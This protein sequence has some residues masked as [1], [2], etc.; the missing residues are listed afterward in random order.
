MSE[1]TGKLPS[2]MTGGSSRYLFR[3]SVPT[4]SQPPSTQNRLKQLEAATS[5][6]ITE[7][8]LDGVL[9]RAVQVSAQVI[10]AKYAAIGVLAPDG[11]M[12]EHFTTHG[13]DSDLAARIGTP[14]RG[15]GILGVVIREAKP[16]RLSDLTKH[17][18][19]YG[20][21]PHHPPMRSFLGV[22]IFGSR[23]V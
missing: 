8:S 12:L 13:I 22:P 18:D 20:F 6:F 19:S 21:P 14:P 10:G 15:H 23:G 2:D 11:R 1:G 7:V 17:P 3:M 4:V 16:I 9:Q 5:A